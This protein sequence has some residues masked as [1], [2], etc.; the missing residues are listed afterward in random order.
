MG[1]GVSGSCGCSTGVGVAGVGVAGTVAQPVSTLER[2][3]RRDDW[4]YGRGHDDRGNNRRND[5]R[6]LC[7]RR[8]WLA[9]RRSD[10]RAAVVAERAAGRHRVPATDAKFRCWIRRRDLW[11]AA[12]IAESHSFGNGC[13]ATIAGCAHSF[14]LF[15]IRYSSSPGDSYPVHIFALGTGRFTSFSKIL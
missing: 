13:S 4:R 12:G 2:H 1:G 6:D 11:R 15:L 3:H 7:C 5:R 8:R 14:L 9:G 10:R